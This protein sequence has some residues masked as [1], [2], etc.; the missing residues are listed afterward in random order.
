MAKEKRHGE[1]KRKLSNASDSNKMIAD[2]K[3]TKEQ[4]NEQPTSTVNNYEKDTQISFKTAEEVTI[5]LDTSNVDLL[6]QG[7][8][9][10]REHLRICNRSDGANAPAQAR[11]L[12]ESCRRVIYEWAAEAGS[13]DFGAF[14]AA[15]QMAYSQ[16]ISRL[17]ML[18]PST[19][20]NLLVT[21]DTPEVL[22][23]G[24]KLIHQVLGEHGRAVT[25]AFATPRSSTCASVL[26]LLY[27]IVV[28]SHGEHADQVWH[29]FNWTM[30][31]LDSLPTIRSNVMGFSI[32]R[33]WIRFV[34]AFFTA[35]KCKTFV[36][37][38]KTRKIFSSLFNGV[39]GDSYQELH[40][41]LSSVY[42]NVVLNEEVP[43]ADKVRVFGIHLMGRL[44]KAAHNVAEVDPQ[45]VGVSSPETFVPKRLADTNTQPAI[46]KDSISALV[47]RFFKGMMTFPGYGI[48][49]HQYGLYTAPRKWASDLAAPAPAS[50]VAAEEKEDDVFAEA[51]D[52][53]DVA[54]FSKSTT[55]SGMKDLCNSQ[56]LRILVG[57]INPAATK[58]MGDLA[59][60]ILRASPELIAPFWRNYGCSFEPRL[61]LR[62]LGNTTF[63]MKVMGLSLPIPKDNDSRFADPPR[64]NTLVEHILPFPLLRT[65]LG[66]GLQ[67]RSSP[68]VRYRNL[69]LIDLALRK[70]TEIREW[71]QTEA[72]ASGTQSAEMNTWKKLD[73]RLLNVVKQRIPEWKVV[74]ALHSEINAAADSSSTPAV[75]SVQPSE[76]SLHEIECQ[77][78]LLD[79][80]LMKVIH[81]YQMHFSDLVMEANFEFGKLISDIRLSDVLPPPGG[82]SSSIQQ[83]R[84]NPIKAH[85]LLYLLRALSTT[86]AS[87]IKWMARTKP[88][89]VGEHGTA[90]Q[91]TNIGVIMIIYLF[92]VQPDLRLAARKVCLWA[93]R[94]TGLFDH[95]TNGMPAASE[96]AL[97]EASCWL[98]ALAAVVSPHAD[99]NKHLSAI[100]EGGLEK[101]YALVAFIEDALGHASRLPYKYADR[102]YAS[103]VQDSDGPGHLDDPLPFSPLLSAVVE[104]AVIKVASGNGALATLL[105]D[106]PSSR[107]ASEMQTNTMYAYIREIVCKI[108]EFCG[109][110]TAQYLS[111]F[112]SDAAKS[113]LAPRLAKLD[114]AK[115]PQKANSER[116]HYT[117]VEK[118]FIDAFSDTQSY[119]MMLGSQHRGSGNSMDP[120]NIP[121]SALPKKVSKKLRSGLEHACSDVG[122]RIVS[123]VDEMVVVL[124]ENSDALTATLLTEWL[125]TQAKSLDAGARQSA[126][127]IAISWISLYERVCAQNRSLWDLPVFVELAPEILQIDDMPFLLAMFRHLLASKSLP[128]LL[129]KE[130]VQR[131]LV[132]ILL[133]NRGSVRFCGFVSHLLQRI[134][135][136][137]QGDITLSKPVVALKDA[138]SSAVLLLSALTAEHLDSFPKKEKYVQVSHQLNQAMEIH[139]FT[140]DTRLSDSG[141]N[142]D[143]QRVLDFNASVLACKSARVW[144]SPQ[145]ARRAW[146][147][148]TVRIAAGVSAFV[149]DMDQAMAKNIDGAAVIDLPS[150][151]CIAS[152]A[153]TDA[154]RVDMLQIFGKAALQARAP[155]TLCAVANAVFTLLNDTSSD[156]VSGCNIDVPQLRSLLSSRVIG[157]WS[158]SLDSKDSEI[159]ASL[160]WTAKLVT[161][162]TETASYIQRKSVL[163]LATLC[164]QIKQVKSQLPD[165][166]RAY[167]SGSVPIDIASMAEHMYQRS[168]DKELYAADAAKHRL[169]ARIISSD[170]VLRCN[171]YKWAET[172]FNDRETSAT[173]IR[174]VVWF[175]YTVAL[176]YVRETEFGFISWDESHA[177]C[178]VRALCLRVGTLLLA[179]PNARQVEALTDYKMIFVIDVVI[180]YCT[181]KDKVDDIC[182][183]ISGLER[184]KSSLA[185]A[186]AVRSET[187][188]AIS[189]SGQTRA[190]VESMGR[191]FPHAK[192]LVPA[193]GDGDLEDAKQTW[194]SVSVLA[195]AIE[196]CWSV[197]GGHSTVVSLGRRDS[198]AAAETIDAAFSCIDAIVRSMCY[199]FA[200]AAEIDAT[201]L[202]RFAEFYPTSVYRFVAFALRAVGS[203]STSSGM[204]SAVAK[205]SWFSLLRCM[206]ACRLF[207]ERMYNIGLRNNLSLV[208]SGLW[209]LAS[210]ALS[211]WSASLDDYFTLDELEALVGAFGGTCSL[212]DSVLQYVISGYENITGQSVQRVALC[213][214]P[215]A[216]DVYIKEKV[217]R[218]RYLIERD[219]NDIGLINEDV[220]SNAV[221]TIDEGK[222]FRT[223]LNF[224]TKDEGLFAKDP[225]AGLLGAVRLAPDEPRNA[226]SYAN[227]DSAAT[228]CDAPSDSEVY[229]SW[230]LL[231]WM[232]S[233][234]SSGEK[235]DARRLIDCNAAGFTLV[236]LSSENPQIRK[237]AYY[238]LDLVY[239]ILADSKR[240]VGQSQC[241]LLLDSV[242][243]TI[244]ERSE[245]NFPQ[246]PF[247]AALFAATSLYTMIHPEHVMYT[248]INRL[249]LKGPCL[250]MNE[251]PLLRTVL[252]SSNSTHKQRI[253]VLRLASQTSRSFDQCRSIIKRSHLVNTLLTLASSSLGDVQT[254]RSALTLLFNL[255]SAT[256]PE[257]LTRHVSKKEFS[258][259]AWIREQTSLELN[260]MQQMAALAS[261]ESQAATSL[262]EG[263]LV[264]SLRGIKA[265]LVN[266]IAILRIVIRAIA[267]YPLVR[268]SGGNLIYNSFWVLKS[269]E[270]A[271]AAGQSTTLDLVQ[272]I[273]GS[274][275]WSLSRTRRCAE[276]VH[277]EIAKPA[278]VLVR[279]CLD[280]TVLLADMQGCAGSEHSNMLE[281]QNISHSALVSLGMLEHA[282]ESSTGSTVVCTDSLPGLSRVHYDPC[283]IVA[284]ANA[285]ATESLFQT[286]VVFDWSSATAVSG[287]QPR[288]AST[289][290]C[291]RQCVERLF[292]LSF[293]MPWTTV[294]REDVAEVVSRALVISAPSSLRVSS[295]IREC[296]P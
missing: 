292:L 11:V 184:S 118:A 7:F 203:L 188:R 108:A 182:H 234:V 164:Q 90:T 104:A 213:F 210:P 146:H 151:V 161:K 174:F 31:S 296:K 207:N 214:G 63:A 88:Q 194:E 45:K 148:F 113:T 33:L 282:I 40:T 263:S 211:R 275:A 227:A 220:V 134:V 15:W 190:F 110:E 268:L 83:Q 156:A 101:G 169:L 60:E 3:E 180:Q 265:S 176:P 5:A 235:L 163:A 132:H 125:L 217:N 18:I 165:F 48:C 38:L 103:V 76:D 127:V 97:S 128:L 239:L 293:G 280:A 202:Q 23:L 44:A 209:D 50:E 224:S 84:R 135:A 215:R 172:A 79:N 35:D 243:N 72:K 145:D 168:K 57:C 247:A 139:A 121:Q 199:A 47:I 100:V 75:E 250:R 20:A 10:L 53:R 59:I 30:S 131:L 249:L 256:N 6:I 259:L 284:I 291:Y 195:S 241:M 138:F 123:F 260:A 162:H 216:A 221:A 87:S 49:F 152:P 1:K 117:H 295:W 274:I 149:E 278:L 236:A 242:C 289:L 34:L 109:Q 192:S 290:E 4:T 157:L 153:M 178:D 144:A 25:R 186:H 231:V 39:E 219:E 189:F 46:A 154:A 130:P 253:H 114:T 96:T 232:W 69:L 193:I 244:T 54:V 158:K 56:I 8:T 116:N 133:A 99:R 150:L 233:V 111:N 119:L 252:Q 294:M 201:K 159:K 19:I 258:L 183:R 229:N 257:A 225:I 98:D 126:F 285:R 61:S 173:G 246:I 171:A 141:D 277:H 67:M 264:S 26:Q 142:K 36:E 28:Y 226:V 2:T 187:L 205:H 27:Q 93:L 81:G 276:R 288:A 112:L 95:D 62:Y 41:L 281:L 137:I 64:L 228:A 74:M 12:Q 175:L 68:L 77:H 240:F 198:N 106:Q 37:I 248:E 185:Q 115:D 55:M 13:G 155:L 279:T 271:G 179:G 42:S 136:S 91:H 9:H 269:P 223:L 262:G 208:V 17:E 204:Q 255:T 270:Q 222:L 80:V 122:N 212:S 82:Y 52:T 94:S 166:D 14:S 58:R 21:L 32:R 206:L 124:H 197:L 251:I 66:R 147:S 218:A 73:R 200:E 237:I 120:V 254:A 140:F 85:T 160:E 70:L 24:N 51:R 287:K 22:S 191:I 89:V 261:I 170:S 71:I 273:L 16:N 238:I 196:H 283:S 266:L 177:A 65:S 107:I 43:R 286:D 167:S 105:R 267:N 245:I 92:A 181:D 78:A 29:S 129:H 86:P 102:V 143:L 272:Q 230:Y